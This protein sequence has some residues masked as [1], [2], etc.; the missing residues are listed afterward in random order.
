MTSRPLG[1]TTLS[2]TLLL[3]A[4]VTLITLY[5]ARFKML[6]QRV[7]GNHLLYERSQLLAYSAW[8]QALLGWQQQATE[9]V[10]ASQMTGT[11]EEARYV[12]T[13]A[14]SEFSNTSWG[15]VEHLS[16]VL[17]LHFDEPSFSRRLQQDIVVAPILYRLPPDPMTTFSADTE[18]MLASLF[19]V[20]AARWP[21]LAELAEV[22]LEN[23]NDLSG[24]QASFIWVQGSCRI[25]H[26][27]GSATAPV[28]L[29]IQ[30]GQLL[31]EQYRRIYGLVLVLTDSIDSATVSVD[32]EF[33]EGSE[34]YG[35]LVTNAPLDKDKYRPW[36]KP[37]EA[38]AKALKSHPN[39]HRWRLIRGSW[40]D[41]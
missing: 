21:L 23:C 30:N 12:A 17:Q 9:I 6:E 5:T 26:D 35:Y 36:I 10:R 29:V 2:I 22:T 4:A 18:D 15:E 39:L 31:V 38:A 25:E 19:A 20:D 11:I 37:S 41:F 27:L 28:I 7:M 24:R 40:R 14:A 8:T 33:A 3:V 13:I 1:F 34:I 32:L 16:I